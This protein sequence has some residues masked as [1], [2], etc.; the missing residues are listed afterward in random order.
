MTATELW[1]GTGLTAL[2][3]VSIILLA[4]ELLAKNYWEGE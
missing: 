3:I 4:G 2:F 1:I